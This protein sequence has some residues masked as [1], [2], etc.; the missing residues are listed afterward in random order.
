MEGEFFVLKSLCVKTKNKKTADYLL[1]SLQELD[2]EGI[3][4]SHS[5]FK[6][7][8][9]VIVH[10]KGDDLNKFLKLTSNV[11]SNTIIS[12]YE[13]KLLKQIIYSNYFYFSDIEQQKILNLCRNYLEDPEF[14]YR[15]SNTNVIRVFSSRLFRKS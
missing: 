14:E 7:Y 8:R 3:Y 11:L 6:V 4:L 15:T 10:Y 12:F 2:L 9:N 5:N 13:T 1:E